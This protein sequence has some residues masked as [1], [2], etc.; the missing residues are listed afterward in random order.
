MEILIE[1][2]SNVKRKSE[3]CSWCQIDPITNDLYKCENCFNFNFC[4]K[5]YLKR[6]EFKT[7]FATT[8][9]IYH[10]FIHIALS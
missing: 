8:H 10:K 4:Q 1:P 7:N 9:K 2:I 3:K 6:E 5:C